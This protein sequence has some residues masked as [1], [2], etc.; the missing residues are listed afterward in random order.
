MIISIT[1]FVLCWILYEK[2]I[3]KIVNNKSINLADFIIKSTHLILLIII[4][5]FILINYINI[6]WILVISS[7]YFIYDLKTSNNNSL[8]IVNYLILIIFLVKYKISES[9]FKLI[10]F[11]FIFN[12]FGNYPIYIMSYLNNHYERKQ[13]IKWRTSIIIWEFLWFIIFR[14][15]AVSYIII[16]INSLYLRFICASFQLFNT[17]YVKK[18]I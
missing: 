13:Y 7:S 11:G 9:D 12:E 8:F 2:I 16:N 17:K 6:N 3:K 14:I 10:I 4:G 1:L 5:I 15:I 18:L